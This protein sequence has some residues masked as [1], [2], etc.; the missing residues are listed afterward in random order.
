M[1]ANNIMSTDTVGYLILK[2]STPNLVTLKC[3]IDFFK[4]Y[5]DNS[6]LY[7]SLSRNDQYVKTNEKSLPAHREENKEIW[8]II[9][10][11]IESF[12][13]NDR[14]Q[15]TGDSYVSNIQ[16]LISQIINKKPLPKNIVFVY[17]Y[18]EHNFDDY[19][20]RITQ[21]IER[22][23]NTYVEDPMYK[24]EVYTVNISKL[25]VKPPTYRIKR[26]KG[27]KNLVTQEQLFYDTG[28]LLADLMQKIFRLQNQDN[29]SDSK[30]IA[31]QALIDVTNTIV[32]D[33]FINFKANFDINI[34]NN[35]KLFND[36]DI[37]KIFLKIF[38]SHPFNEQ[39]LFAILILLAKDK[40]NSI[41]KLIHDKKN[42]DK[43]FS[44]IQILYTLKNDDAK[45][46]PT[47]PVIKTSKSNNKR[48]VATD[49]QSLSQQAPKT[50][51]S[52]SK[53]TDA[54]DDQSLSQ[55][56]PKTSKSNSKET[57]ATDDQSLITKETLQQMTNR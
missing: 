55:Q 27:A 44:I 19:I 12:Y 16:Y 20:Q 49:D 46:E 24:E 25:Y 21:D 36:D 51:K 15:Y 38:R 5:N 33:A 34:D 42:N 48:N 53:K 47:R 22:T 3:I 13:G 8:N 14:L 2:E 11:K 7:Y 54:T 50:S 26:G 32:D 4:K 10:Y 43:L 40:S 17:S 41:Y 1:K 56:A 28:A 29:T 37:I 35:I 45:V 39:M 57:D 23:A 52:N 30:N 6:I 18:D 31:Q 9:K